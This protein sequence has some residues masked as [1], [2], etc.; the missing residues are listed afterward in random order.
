MPLRLDSDE[1]RDW[2][3]KIGPWTLSLQDCF[4]RRNPVTCVEFNPPVVSCKDKQGSHYWR[5]LER[6]EGE[7]VG[8][9]KQLKA[10]YR[11]LKSNIERGHFIS[12]TDSAARQ[13]RIHNL[14]MVRLLTDSQFTK[15][16]FE[17][18]ALVLDPS[19]T[20]LH[21][22]RNHS[23]AWTDRFLRHCCRHGFSNLLII[24]GD[25]LPDMKLPTCEED[26]A[27]LLLG[28]ER[29]LKR[30]KNSVALT[31]YVKRVQPE[32]FVGVA[33]NPF[34]GPLNHYQRK[35]QAGAQFAVTQPVAYYAES[36]QH[37]ERF[38][39]ERRELGPEIPVVVGVFNYFVPCDAHGF[40]ANDFEHRQ[41]FWKKLF[42]YV[43][44]GVRQ[45]YERGLDGVE[46]LARS[47]QK[48]KQIGYFHVDVM[49]A[50]RSGHQIIEQAKRIVHEGDRLQS[51]INDP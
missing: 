21:L 9:I 16:H 39:Q 44:S 13:Q 14:S 37:M 36:W 48:L 15:R 10:K 8:V 34:R 47:I 24:T 49:N 17:G 20:V 30:L 28:R 26:E 38:E 23:V 3:R 22:T 45:D 46:I 32:F 33:H 42:G 7:D 12:I 31:A 5:H 2:Q 25:P 1:R 11:A 27:E 50:E 51:G 18:E 35:L 29:E 4:E 19:R 41:A 43:P 40:N 6:V